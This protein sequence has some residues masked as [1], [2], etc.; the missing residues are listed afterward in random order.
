MR[1]IPALLL[2]AGLLLV[3]SMAQASKLYIREY[4]TISTIGPIIAQIAPEPGVDQAPVDFSSG[5]A[6]SAAFASTTH[7]VRVVCDASC[8]IVFGPPGTVATT[9]NAFLAA[10]IP[11]YFA[12]IPSQIISVH[13]NP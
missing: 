4:K 10:G 1:K 13:S 5:A 8:S 2:A 7:V 6:P 11:E 12:V 3:P 9:S